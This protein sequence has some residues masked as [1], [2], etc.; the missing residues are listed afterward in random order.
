[1]NLRARTRQ[2]AK[3]PDKGT[4]GLVPSPGGPQFH[5]NQVGAAL[6]KTGRPGVN[7]WMCWEKMESDPGAQT[8]MFH[9]PPS[10][11]CASACWYHPPL[12]GEMFEN[13]GKSFFPK[14]GG[15]MV[16]GVPTSGKKTTRFLKKT[17]RFLKNS[18][19]GTKL[20]DSGT[21][22]FFFSHE[23]SQFLM[24][25]VWTIVFSESI[26]RT[27]RGTPSQCIRSM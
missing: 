3:W 11:C 24:M 14:K 10:P 23:S 13:S 26:C 1:M 17:T 20:S 8:V 12:S 18:D 27:P 21:N 15:K 2:P 19:A 25:D 4:F 7:I 22:I 9:A 6:K 16:Y 5:G